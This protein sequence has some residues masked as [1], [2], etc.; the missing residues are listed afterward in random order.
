MEVLG[1]AAVSYERGTPVGPMLP[2]VGLLFDRVRGLQGY[3][4]HEKPPTPQDHH[5]ALGVGLLLGF[6]GERFRMSAVPLY[7]GCGKA[8]FTT[9]R[10][11]SLT[12][13]RTPLGPYR[14]P[15]PRVLGG[16]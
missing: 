15:M 8:A 6:K 10:V 5:R 2:G 1:G 4:A 3:L 7:R 11:T 9:Y 12:R 16:S 14:R 13:K